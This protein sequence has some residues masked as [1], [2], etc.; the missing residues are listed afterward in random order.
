MSSTR[1]SWIVTLTLALSL[2]ACGGNASSHNASSQSTTAAE[3]TPP[4]STGETSRPAAASD[5]RGTANA[6]VIGAVSMM[7]NE[8][9][10]VSAEGEVRLGRELLGVLDADGRLSRHGALVAE[11]RAGGAIW[12]GGEDTG[13]RVE[14]TSLH[15]AEGLMMHIEGGQ[16]IV[17]G[18]VEDE[19]PEVITIEGYRP[20][21][22]REVLFVMG[23]YVAAMAAAYSH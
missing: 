3:A 10:V 6:F 7:L 14:G 16:L 19:R 12:L 5:D 4:P 9:L 21:L 15:A 1:R 23:S 20:E 8:P 13:M 22:A 2:T 18:E 17:G 11:L